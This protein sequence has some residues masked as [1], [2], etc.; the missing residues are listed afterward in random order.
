MS[1]DISVT[2]ALENAGYYYSVSDDIYE[3]GLDDGD[4]LV[5]QRIVSSE[6]RQRANYTIIVASDADYHEAE[7][8]LT[9][10]SQYHDWSNTIADQVFSALDDHDGKN[11]GD[12]VDADLLAKY[13]EL[14][15]SYNQ[16]GDKEIIPADA[17]ITPELVASIGV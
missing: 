6:N 8:E 14:I 13:N 1:D 9:V 16:Y 7:M 11:V 12:V 3:C 4:E 15:R 10:T 17:V 5:V 2:E